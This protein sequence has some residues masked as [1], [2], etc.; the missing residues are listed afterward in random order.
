MASD[1]AVTA[2]ADGSGDL[3][4]PQGGVFTNRDFVKLFSG[5]MVSLIG[6]Q[7]TQ[8][9]MPLVAILTL[10][11]TVFEVGILNALR[12]A[13]VIVVALFAG[14]WLDRARR[15]PVLIGC[16]LCCAVLIG[17]VPLA[18]AT[19]HLSLGLLYV[20]AVLVGGLNV[21]FDIGALSYVPNLVEPRHL[22]EANGKIQ[23]I[24]AFS[25]ISGPAIAGLLVGL[26]TAPITM[27][28]DAVSYLF[29]AAGLLSIKQPEPAPEIPEGRIPVHRQ[30]AEGFRAVYG[31]PVLRAL[32][33]Q[34]SLLNLAFGGL[35][36]VF[37]VYALRNLH[38]HPLELG[39]VV[40]SAAVGGLAGA[41]GTSKLR[42]A[43]GLGRSMILTTIGASLG[44]LLLLVPHNASAL[45]VVI[46]VIAQLVYG[47]S[48]QVFNVNAITL[49]QVVTPRRL[50]ARMNATYRMLLFGVAPL[51]AIIGGLLGEAT[52]VRVA[53]EITVFAMLTP[54]LWLLFSPVFRL[55]EIP[56]GPPADEGGKGHG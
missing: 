52:G 9:A 23:A 31:G 45:S 8:F 38:L 39:I 16:S 7:I 10:R 25:G 42:V 1:Q 56:A 50:L 2:A 48:I 44:P 19:G 30:I 3:N 26:I 49:R 40:G 28:A 24:R 5:E 14:V 47:T 35:W 53:L 33:T 12:L 41:L 34:S 46:L 4:E 20:V 43:I 11:A 13:P 55:K 15:R 21:V 51:G 32:L 22:P 54:L 6:T 17:L 37:L 36:P 18:S 27:S 29:S